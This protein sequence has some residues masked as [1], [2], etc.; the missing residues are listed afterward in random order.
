VPAYFE[1]IVASY[2]DGNKNRCAHLGH[3]DSVAE[4]ITHSGS[5]ET[6]S[7]P[8][9]SAGEFQA[10]QQRLDEQMIRLAQL[11]HGQSVLDAGC[12]LGGLIERIN[13]HWSGMEVTGLNVDPEQLDI[14]HRIRPQS[15]N[16]LRWQ[17]GDACQLPFED[18]LF[19]R[20]FCVE[21]MFHFPSRR[22]FLAEVLRVLKPGGR[23]V[24]SDI[25]LLDVPHIESFPRFAVAAILNDGYGPWPDPWCDQGSL[26]SLG[27]ELGFRELTR[28]DATSNTLPTYDF[29][30]P[31]RF[32]DDH[33][34]GD[35][36]TRAALM[37]RWL[38]RSSALRYEYFSASKSY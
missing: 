32:D 17:E 24:A 31:R 38:H 23:F 1:R 33:D 9:I 12:G 15:G 14:C 19:D 5:S 28:I 6:A 29:I 4:E 8:L 20:V 2:H 30:V 34:P 13:E 7:P 36:A 10:A 27:D 22:K 35:P 16:S 21:A 26:S 37:L 18:Q 25:V 11:N 3:W